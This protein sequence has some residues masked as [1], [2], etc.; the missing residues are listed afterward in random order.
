MDDRLAYQSRP[1]KIPFFEGMDGCG[2]CKRMQWNRELAA[3]SRKKWQQDFHFEILSKAFLNHASATAPVWQHLGPPMERN[4]LMWIL[5]LPAPFP[6]RV[7][8][9]WYLMNN[10]QI[11]EGLYVLVADQGSSVEEG[12]LKQVVGFWAKFRIFM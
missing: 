4:Y 8:I 2:S 7:W 1:P 12:G 6:H 11:L 10:I 3:G 9:P 5:L